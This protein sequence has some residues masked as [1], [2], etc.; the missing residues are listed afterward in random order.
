[1][2][3]NND[4]RKLLEQKIIRKQKNEFNL[5]YK[6]NGTP[7]AHINKYRFVYIFVQLGI[8]FFFYFVFLLLLFPSLFFIH[9]YVCL[10]LCSYFY[11][12][13]RRRR[14]SRKI[15]IYFTRKI[16][17]ISIMIIYYIIISKINKNITMA[18]FYIA[19]Y[20]RWDGFF[21]L[22]ELKSSIQLYFHFLKT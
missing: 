14:K 22:L 16:I 11:F 21:F 15:I 17:N 6:R 8:L 20:F 18:S 7:F 1:M 4:K 13:W 19:K 10:S 5:L 12:I 9:S 3:E 2:W